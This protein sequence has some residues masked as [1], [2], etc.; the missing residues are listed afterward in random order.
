MAL[1]NDPHRFGTVARALHWTVFLLFVAQYVGGVL[2][3]R[4]AR[5]DTVFGWAQGTWFEWH[6]SLGL[7]VL[8][9]MTARLS[10]RLAMPLPEWSPVLDEGERR[11]TGWL[12]RLMYLA[13]F[14]APLSGFV[15]VMAGGYGIKL[16]DGP[17]LPNPIG[18]VPWLEGPAHAVHLVTVWIAMIL[19]S[20]HVGHVLK[21]EFVDLMPLLTRMLP[22]GRGDRH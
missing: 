5:G 10:W 12:E 3:S 2:M 16:F 22:F 11:L 14:V 7:V 4:V 13:L 8:L 6:K 18:K 21:K 15:F 9:V 19:A 1:K 17:A 20:W